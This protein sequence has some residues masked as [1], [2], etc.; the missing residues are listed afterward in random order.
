[1]SVD[2]QASSGSSAWPAGPWTEALTIVVPVHGRIDATLRF[3]ESWR[4]QTRASHLVFVDDC[5]PDET[6]RVLREE[7][8]V[9]VERGRL[10]FNGILNLAVAECRTT[11]LGVLN[12]DLVLGRR[13]VEQVLDAFERS[14]S[15]FLVPC[16]LEEGLASPA[17]LERERRFRIRRLRRQQGWCMLFRTA[18]VRRLPPVPADLRLWYG[19]SWLFHHAWEAGQ[20][21][22]IL[23]HV[24]V[25]HQRHAT[26][27]SDATFRRT[28]VHPVLAEDERVFRERYGWIRT[29]RLGPWRFVP[30]WLRRKL[31]PFS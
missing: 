16:T 29:K 31:V 30:R 13:F 5:S 21:L 15:D 4:P 9:V 1:M 22:G 24:P 17:D 14:D 6:V 28:G 3:L 26:I 11:Y 8:Q 2:P 12:N 25:I 20:K 7:G 27:Q 23:M 18:S 10:Y 19:D